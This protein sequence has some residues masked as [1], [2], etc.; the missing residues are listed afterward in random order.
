MCQQP[1]PTAV[2]AGHG[3]F[4]HGALLTGRSGQDS[5]TAPARAGR[6]T[7]PGLGYGGTG[8]EGGEQFGDL[9]GEG[10]ELGLGRSNETPE[11]FGRCS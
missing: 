5:P 10:V 9:V 8:T 6:R 1:V 2:T 7:P 4:G 3:R 11:P